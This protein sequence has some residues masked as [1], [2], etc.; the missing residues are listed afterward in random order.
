MICDALDWDIDLMTPI[1][2]IEVI[3]LHVA[4]CF[5]KDLV[6]KLSYELIVLCLTGKD[7][8]HTHMMIV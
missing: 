8:W 5:A 4:Y 7:T 6:R 2:Y 1:K 3:L